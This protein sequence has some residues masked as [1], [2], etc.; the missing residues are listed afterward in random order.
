MKYNYGNAYL[1]DPINDGELAVWPDGS[2][3][4]VHDIFEDNPDFFSKADLI[5]VDPPWNLGNLNCFY[6]KANRSD[7]QES[8]A[9]F[10]QALFKRIQEVSAKTCYVEVGK[11]YLADFIVEMRKIYPHVTF[12]NSYYYHSKKNHCYVIRGS[13]KAKKP[14]LDDMDEENIIKWVCENEEYT[15]ILDPCM[16]QGL[17]GKYASGA[18]RMFVGGELNPK[19]LSV[20]LKAIPGYKI[21]RS[22]R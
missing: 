20:L 2:T 21:E 17:V 19:R 6:T 5:F 11:Q 10:Y 14:S 15:C 3:V 7:Y 8:F 18:N 1:S 13:M 4:A 22:V 12:Y 16:G 9:T